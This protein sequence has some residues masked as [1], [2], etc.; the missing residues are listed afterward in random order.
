M[1]LVPQIPEN[2]PKQPEDANYTVNDRRGHP[3]HAESKFLGEWINGMEAKILDGEVA[4]P[5]P[6]W[7]V[8]GI[9]DQPH[10]R[11]F[12]HGDFLFSYRVPG[13]RVNLARHK[14]SLSTCS[15]CHTGD[16]STR[17]QMIRSSAHQFDSPGIPKPA[18]MAKFMVGDDR[19]EDE[20]LPHP[21]HHEVADLVNKEEKH[22]FFDLQ[23]R[24]D[25]I[26]D[27][28]KVID[29]IYEAKIGLTQV[30]FSE[31]PPAGEPLTQVFVEG[32]ALADWEFS[33]ISGLGDSNNPDFSIDADGT[34]RLVNT[35][36]TTHDRAAQ[37]RIQAKATDGSSVIIERPVS[38]WIRKTIPDE[39]GS[40]SGPP[41]EDPDTRATLEPVMD[42]GISVEIPDDHDH[43]TLDE[44]HD[45]QVELPISDEHIALPDDHAHE[46]HHEHSVTLGN[47]LPTFNLD[48]GLHRV[49][50][51]RPIFFFPDMPILRIPEFIPI[52]LPDFETP[53]PFRTH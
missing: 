47:E 28:L 41:H 14:F 31:L 1:V 7:M 17:F 34:I 6:G 51:D 8:G 42:D 53:R 30:D 27:A 3:L 46:D 38:L 20:G 18:F 26:R 13:V 45:V 23:S 16:T 36:T 15:G 35:F 52:L 19:R 40:T 11:Q 37:V 12:N 44:H 32:G 5:S 21:L 39:S 50:F 2:A 43:H 49:D 24:E 25:I 29:L 48:Q 4:P 9:S 10:G 33:L 22:Y